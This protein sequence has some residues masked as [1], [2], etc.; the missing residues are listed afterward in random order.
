MTIRPVKIVRS[1]K[2][3]RLREIQTFSGHSK[4]IKFDVAFVPTATKDAKITIKN[5]RVIVTSK[6]VSEVSIPFNLSALVND[7]RAELERVIRE[8]PEFT[9]FIVQV[10]EDGKFLFNGLLQP[11]T[12][13]MQ[14]MWLIERYSPGGAA[15]KGPANHYSRWLYGLKGVKAKSQSEA[16][17]YLREYKRE[18]LKKKTSAK[19]ARRSEVKKYGRKLQS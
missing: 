19:K 9:Q 3:D 11:G 6:Y 4:K 8:N 7:P 2:K 16:N 1:K 18:A 10:G 13:A 14:V 17:N 5:G 12:A 15:Y